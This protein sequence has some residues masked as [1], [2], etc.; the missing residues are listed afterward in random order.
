MSFSYG[1]STSNLDQVRRWI[2]DTDVTTQLVS[3]EE[4]NSELSINSNDV[5]KVAANLSIMLASKFARRAIS[6][7]ASKYSEDLKAISKEYRE[8]AKIILEGGVEP[9]DE[10]AEQTFSP[11]DEK[12]F[13]NKE[14]LRDDI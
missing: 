5:R 11:K 1:S 9:W 4:I 8:Q 13:T 7:K 10:T 3:D 12:I 6:K 2:W 14:F